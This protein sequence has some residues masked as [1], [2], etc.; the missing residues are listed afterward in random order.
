MATA[1]L[2]ARIAS[3]LSRQARPLVERSTPSSS[4]TYQRYVCQCRSYA[5]H[6]S[7]AS[8]RQRATPRQARD[9]Q[10]PDRGPQSKEDT[11]TDFGALNVL[12]AAPAPT[13][14]VDVCISDGFMLDSGLRIEDGDGLLLIGSEAF[15]WRPWM[16]QSSNNPSGGTTSSARERIITGS[17]MRRRAVEKARAAG[18]KSREEERTGGVINSR[19]Q[20]EVSTEAFGVLGAVWPRPD[21]L[22]VGTGPRI[23]PLAPATK[24]A[25]QELGFRLEVLDTR[26]AASQFNLLA[27]ERGT[28][29]VA[30]V[31]VPIGFGEV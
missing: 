8:A 15:V 6:S 1:R 10:D 27:T 23:L 3:N 22:I 29:E 18:R 11:V 12:G 21:I 19:G 20:F 13:T 30:A 7:N 31:L 2:Q 9:L 26:N 4:L 5:N 24:S 17:L 25:L 16:A 28:D 14:S